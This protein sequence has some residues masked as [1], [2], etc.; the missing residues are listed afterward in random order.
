MSKKLFDS[1]K[2]VEQKETLKNEKVQEKGLPEYRP[3]LDFHDNI[4]FC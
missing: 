2:D 3:D 4:K 1:Y